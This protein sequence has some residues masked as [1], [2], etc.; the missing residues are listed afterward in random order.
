MRRAHC[1]LMPDRAGAQQTVNDLLL[2]QDPPFAQPA[3]QQP[4]ARRLSLYFASARPAVVFRSDQTFAPRNS[5]YSAQQLPPKIVHGI[6]RV[7]LIVRGVRQT[8]N[9]GAG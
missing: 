3:N 1:W 7:H 2:A 4:A 9:V 6:K 8:T 5:P